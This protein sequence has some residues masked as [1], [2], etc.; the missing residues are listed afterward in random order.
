MVYTLARFPA[1]AAFNAVFVAVFGENRRSSALASHAGS[2]YWLGSYRP[3]AD[4]RDDLDDFDT[5]DTPLSTDVSLGVR[6][7]FGAGV[8]PAYMLRLR[9][10]PESFDAVDCGLDVP[11]PAAAAAW[12]GPGGAG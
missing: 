6:R 9:V 11:T 12:T 5:P 1:T 4:L 7:S 8:L 10:C 2:W 3:Y